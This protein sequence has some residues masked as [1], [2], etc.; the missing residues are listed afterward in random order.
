[1][2][3]HA[4]L[5]VGVGFT[6][7]L[8]GIT[9]WICRV[10][11]VRTPC[12]ERIVGYMHSDA[13]KRRAQQLEQ[14]ITTIFTCRSVVK[15]NLSVDERQQEKILQDIDASLEVLRGCVLDNTA[16]QPHLD[17]LPF[18][19]TASTTVVRTTDETL[20]YDV[21]AHE[22]L[23]AL[24]RMYY[25]FLDINE[26]TNL[27]S[28]VTR[29]NEA[30]SVLGE[31][32]R[33][34]EQRSPL[35]PDMYS[36]SVVLNYS[37]LPMVLE[38]LLQKVKVFISDLYYVFMDFIR[39]LSAVLEQ[40]NV[41]LNTDKLT[42]LPERRSARIHRIQLERLHE[43]TASLQSLQ[44]ACLQLRWRRLQVEP[45]MSGV[46]VFLEFLKETLRGSD[47]KVSQLSEI[48]VQTDTVSLLLAELL[49]IVA[50]YEKITLRLMQST[51]NV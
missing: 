42:S 35:P 3:K 19:Q 31:V 36:S 50:D 33:L 43:H 22:T 18:S 34:F 26:K 11:G 1:M 40:N 7:V 12:R 32:Q 47:V 6:P 39:T 10:V 25:A 38:G 27:Q 20:R 51:G 2:H 14:V 9:S 16:V 15:Y 28:F 24:Y 4:M 29:F 37:P 17:D 45:Q 23:Q 5:C 48:L 21:N 46:T 13:Q 8:T 41:H 44:E 49:H 30:I